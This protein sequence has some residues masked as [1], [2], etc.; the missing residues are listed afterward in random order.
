VNTYKGLWGVR[1]GVVTG[2]KRLPRMLEGL[3]GMSKGMPDMFQGFAEMLECT[4]KKDQ[5]G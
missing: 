5:E 4:R 1:E 2:L 3:L